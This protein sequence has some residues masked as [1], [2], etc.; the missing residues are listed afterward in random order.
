VAELDHVAV[1][2][3]V[4]LALDA[5]VA[6]SPGG[7]DHDPDGQPAEVG[8]VGDQLGRCSIVGGLLAFAYR[9]AVPR[10]SAGPATCTPR[11]LGRACRRLP[12]SQSP[13]GVRYLQQ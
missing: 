11:R 13:S 1:A 5:H 9:R 12:V 6:Y 3:D 10:R 7:G 8:D 2:H 4:V